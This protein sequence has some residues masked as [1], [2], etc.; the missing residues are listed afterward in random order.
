MSYLVDIESKVVGV[1]R[2]RPP[3][4]TTNNIS[5]L[6]VL[7]LFEPIFVTVLTVKKVGFLCY[8]G[9]TKGMVITTTGNGFHWTCDY[10][11]EAR[12]I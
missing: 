10:T 9:S 6:H 1:E 8:R 12:P 4:P 5:K 7:R 11:S 3:L 2:L